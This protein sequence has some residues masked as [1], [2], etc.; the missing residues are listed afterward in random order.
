MPQAR[1]MHEESPEISSASATDIN[2]APKLNL[3]SPLMNADLSPSRLYSGQK[4]EH[5]VKRRDKQKLGDKASRLFHQF[6]YQ[7]S[8]ERERIQINLP[9]GAAS[10]SASADINTRAYENV[11]CIWVKR[12]I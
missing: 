2:T 1:W 7:V 8:K 9:D 5:P 4:L 6:I 3:F 10:A 11:K 12:G